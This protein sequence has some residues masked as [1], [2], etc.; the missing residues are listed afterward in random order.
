LIQSQL[1][2]RCESNRAPSW[3]VGRHEDR[4]AGLRITLDRRHEQQGVMS[5]GQLWRYVGRSPS[6]SSVRSARCSARQ[7]ERRV[8]GRGRRSGRLAN[9]ADLLGRNR[10][11]RPVCSGRRGART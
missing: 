8:V 2:A 7:T 6:S 4:P 5:A 10:V 11:R 9:G 3:A 1:G